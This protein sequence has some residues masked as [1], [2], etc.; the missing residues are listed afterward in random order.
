NRGVPMKMTLKGLLETPEVCLAR[1]CLRRLNDVTDTLAT[2]EIVSLADSAEP[3]AWLADRLAH[4][5]ACDPS[6]SSAD[7]ETPQPA[8]HT[9]GEDRHP[10]VR[11]LAEL[12]A[13]SA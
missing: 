2:A 7:G 4:L 5:G 10:I 1:A 11:R 9:W 3:E 13:E 6:G 12:R 8:G